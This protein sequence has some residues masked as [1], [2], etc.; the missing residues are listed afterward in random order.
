MDR[1]S[2]RRWLYARG[3]LSSVIG[4]LSALSRGLIVYCLEEAKLTKRAEWT[5]VMSTRL[6]LRVRRM[7]DQYAGG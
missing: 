1:R 4:L 6:V 3:K 2:D 5:R 7:F